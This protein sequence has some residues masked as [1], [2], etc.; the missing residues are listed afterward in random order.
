[1]I[2]TIEGPNGRDAVSNEP[3]QGQRYEITVSG[4]G[5]TLRINGDDGLCWAR[6]SKR[7]GIDVHGNASL[8]S[9]ASE[10]VLYAVHKGHTSD[11]N[12]LCRGISFGFAEVPRQQGFV[13]ACG[14]GAYF[15]ERDHEFG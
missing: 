13:V 7:F 5:E 2:A 12:R 14:L 6:F 15:G 8:Q 9:A 10:F 1:M 11:W 4:N 3:M